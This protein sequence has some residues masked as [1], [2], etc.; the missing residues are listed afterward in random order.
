VQLHDG[1]LLHGQERLWIGE[2]NVEKEGKWE[3]G[4]EKREGTSADNLNTVTIQKRHTKK[5][6]IGI[7]NQQ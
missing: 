5:E 6:Q 3:G 4:K 2:G 7:Q 1:E